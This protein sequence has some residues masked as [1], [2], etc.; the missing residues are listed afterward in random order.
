MNIFLPKPRTIDILSYFPGL[1]EG[2]SGIR[3]GWG[4]ETNGR[5]EAERLPTSVGPPSG[6]RAA[7]LSPPHLHSLYSA[8]P[9]GLV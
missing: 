6:G 1:L 9:H 3:V 5:F 8:R 4:I 7:F 2:P